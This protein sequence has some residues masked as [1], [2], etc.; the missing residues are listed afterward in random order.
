[1]DK[2][3]KYDRHSHE[4]ACYL[5]GEI[6]GYEKTYFDAERLLES[7]AYDLLTSAVTQQPAA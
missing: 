6:V 5:N 7:L 4:Y 1:M 2:V 3:I